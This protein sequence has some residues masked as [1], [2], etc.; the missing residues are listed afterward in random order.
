[1]Y[2]LADYAMTTQH[3]EGEITWE[4]TFESKLYKG[5]RPRATMSCNIKLTCASPSII[6]NVNKFSRRESARDEPNPSSAVEESGTCVVD[7]DSSGV[8][9]SGRHGTR[10]G[11]MEKI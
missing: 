8:E 2:L 4:P 3:G 11:G 9:R 7:Y 5:T 6:L 10:L 1:M